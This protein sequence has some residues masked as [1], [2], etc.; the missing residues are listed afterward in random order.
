MDREHRGGG[1][2][3]SPGVIENVQLHHRAQRVERGRVDRPGLGGGGQLVQRAHRAEVCVGIAEEQRG[4]V[5]AHEPCVA[6]E[7]DGLEGVDGLDFADGVAVSSDGAHVYVAGRHDDAVVVFHTF[8]GDGLIEAPEECDDG[9]ATDA[10][11]C[12]DDCTL[13]TPDAPDTDGD[14]VD[15]AKEKRLLQ[16]SDEDALLPVVRQVLDAHQGQVSQFLAGKESLVGFFI[17]QV[18]RTFDGSP[19]PRRVRELLAA[20]LERRRGA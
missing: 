5:G 19:D 6:P 16:V 15:F 12:D 9:N 18:M 20:E 2:R 10:D 3:Q 8:C 17:G 4:P 13:G 14:P 7:R 1:R 11:G